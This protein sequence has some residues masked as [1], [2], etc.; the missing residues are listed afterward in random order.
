VIVVHQMFDEVYNNTGIGNTRRIAKFLLA[1][2]AMHEL[3]VAQ[4]SG[5]FQYSAA[6]VALH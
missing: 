2:V 1:P 4:C 6:K 3:E 5:F